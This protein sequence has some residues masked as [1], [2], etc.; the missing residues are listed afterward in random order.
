MGRL[1]HFSGL[2]SDMQK[3]FL[4]ASPPD[5]DCVV[6]GMHLLTLGV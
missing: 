3:G 4:D 2:N 5:S 6:R 1:E